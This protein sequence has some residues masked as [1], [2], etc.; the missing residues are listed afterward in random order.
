MDKKDLLTRLKPLPGF[1]D[2]QPFGSAWAVWVESKTL[3]EFA[4]ALKEEAG[5]ELDWLENLSV[6]QIEEALLLT[7]FL[8]RHVGRA[9]LVLRATVLPQTEGARVRVPSVSELWPEAAAYERA[10]GELFGIDFNGLPP[11][12]SGTAILPEGWEGYPMRKAYA[13][14]AEVD[15]V[16]HVRQV[17]RTEAKA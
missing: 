6:S 2:I 3:V 10:A 13:F 9:Q 17:G 5:L 12:A 7:Y 1:V 8:R 14:P 4:R 16:P 15:G 11:L